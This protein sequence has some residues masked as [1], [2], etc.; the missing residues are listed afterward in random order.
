[1]STNKETMKKTVLYF[2]ASKAENWNLLDFLRLMQKEYKILLMGDTL[3]KWEDRFYT[4]LND[5]ANLNKDEI[6]RKEFLLEP[7]NMKVIIYVIIF[8]L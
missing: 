2:K 7:K 8:V 4:T 6:S 1:M 3:I 5:L